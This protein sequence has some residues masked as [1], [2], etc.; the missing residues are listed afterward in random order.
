MGEVMQRLQAGEECHCSMFDNRQYFNLRYS[1][2]KSAVGL[3][4]NRRA[5]STHLPQSSKANITQDPTTSTLPV[6]TGAGRNASERG[7]GDLVFD[8]KSDV[9]D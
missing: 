4:G 2:R 6:A 3:V 1:V 5:L 9:T 8:V 7:T